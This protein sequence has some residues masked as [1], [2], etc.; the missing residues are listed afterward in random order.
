MFIHLDNSTKNLAV[1]G[2]FQSDNILGPYTYVKDI[3]PSG[4]DARDLG[5]YI[6]D[7]KGYVLYACGRG[8]QNKNVG[9]CISQL[10]ENFTDVTGEPAFIGQAYC[11]NQCWEAPAIMPANG[12]YYMIVSYPTTYNTNAGQ[13]FW[14]PN[15]P[16]GPW[17]QMGNLSPTSDSYNSQVYYILPLKTPSGATKYLYLA[18][19]W[20][21]PHTE[22]ATYVWLPVKISR[23]TDLTAGFE[24]LH[25]LEDQWDLD[26]WLNEEDNGDYSQNLFIQ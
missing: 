8:D 12:G 3:K 2:I 21:Y 16:Q 24:L 20:W 15:F 1:I 23:P 13:I 5:A 19:R 17:I 4:L 7:G 9:I 22:N 6:V 11:S 25:G 26:Q 10:T 14:T 18:D